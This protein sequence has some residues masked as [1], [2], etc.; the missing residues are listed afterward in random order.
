VDT[1][2]KPCLV[3]RYVNGMV[4]G[5]EQEISLFRGFDPCW[6]ENGSAAGSADAEITVPLVDIFYHFRNDCDLS[7]AGAVMGMGKHDADSIGSVQ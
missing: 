2:K 4:T 7:Q 6:Q 3:D 1:G 5:F